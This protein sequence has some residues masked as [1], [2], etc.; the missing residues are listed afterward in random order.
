MRLSTDPARDEGAALAVLHAAL[1]AGVTLLDTSDAYCRDEADAGHNER[2]IAQALK[3]W[4]GDRARVLVAT[5]GGLR[6][7]AGRWVADGRA[8][9]L[10]AACDAS[11]R[12]LGVDRI[13]LYQLH[14]PDP[15]TPLATSVRALEA[16]KRDGAIEAIGLCNVSVRQIE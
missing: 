5:K 1:D 12:A 14:A 13:A 8:K 4:R 16:L 3:T 15:R 6:R 7:P 10:A 2:L 11:R 9:H